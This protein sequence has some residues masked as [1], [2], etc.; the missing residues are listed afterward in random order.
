MVGIMRGMVVLSDSFSSA[1]S[2]AAGQTPICPFS[3]PFP[4]FVST[5]DF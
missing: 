4:S 5:L 2:T 3:R 1:K